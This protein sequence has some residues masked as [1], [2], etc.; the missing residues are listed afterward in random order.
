MTNPTF[1]LT[2]LDGTKIP[3]MLSFDIVP[4]PTFMIHELKDGT[5]LGGP[6]YGDW[7]GLA[8]G[9]AIKEMNDMGLMTWLRTKLIPWVKHALI[10]SYGNR[11]A[12]TATIPPTVVPAGP[13]TPENAL[14]V[15]NAALSGAHWADTDG[16]GLPELSFN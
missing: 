11:V 12:T 4:F 13:I 5:W 9:D 3:L 16:D 6:S 10:N 2:A 14:A 1:T 8:W 15:I 7:F